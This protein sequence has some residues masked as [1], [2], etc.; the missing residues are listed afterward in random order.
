MI[1]HM[2]R[3]MPW[4]VLPASPRA[5]RLPIERPSYNIPTR[6]RAIR[7]AESSTG[8]VSLVRS[9]YR[10]S[11]SKPVEAGQRIGSLLWE[12]NKLLSCMQ[13]LQKTSD[14]SNSMVLL[15]EAKKYE[16]FDRG[17]I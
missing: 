16:Q 4:A 6:N 12:F 17:R 10:E 11:T 8:P 13:R 2:W 9:R 1:R 5:V 3:P 15:T 14:T 7:A